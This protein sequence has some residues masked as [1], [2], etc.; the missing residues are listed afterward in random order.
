L[1][2]FRSVEPRFFVAGD[3]IKPKSTYVKSEFALPFEIAKK[4]D[5]LEKAMADQGQKVA[6]VFQLL[7]EVTVTP[8]RRRRAGFMPPPED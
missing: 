5:E 1:A 6:A 4:I 3:F 2:P 7:R 8:K